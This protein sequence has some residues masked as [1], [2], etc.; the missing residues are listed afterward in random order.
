MS[1][2]ELL[3]KPSTFLFII[4]LIMSVIMVMLSYNLVIHPQASAQNV[5]TPTTAVSNGQTPIV[6]KTPDSNALP[7][8]SPENILGVSGDPGVIYPGISWVRIGYPTC[9]WGKLT[10]ELLRTTIQTYHKA[11]LRVLL[12]FCQKRNDEHLFDVAPLN[13]VAQ[14][15]A[16]AVQCGNEEMKLDPA[17]SF[18]FIPPERFARFYDLCE[19]TV[20]SIRP[21]LPVLLGSLDPHVGG[22]DYQ[23]LVQQKQYLDQMQ[24][25]MNT[26]VHAGGH[27]D[28][29]TQTLGLIDSWHNGWN[30]NGYPDAT[31]N[32]LQGLFSFWAEQ[33][34]V[35]LNSGQLGKHLWI[36]EGTGCFKG[37]GIDDK[38]PAQVAK[39]HIIALLTDVQTALKYSVPFFFFSAK[40]FVDQGYYWPIGLLDE[41]G[42]AKALRQD[43]PMGA[44]ALVLACTDGSITVVDQFQLLVN[45]YH[46]C[47]LPKDAIDSLTQ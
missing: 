43:L 34:G 24:V 38:N 31:V 2:P 45:L 40:D 36:V 1:L 42:K 7:V 15:M 6:E 22:I 28:W 10:G 12:I 27:W 26:T 29:H 35:D 41:Q 14:G 44:R 11:G 4:T 47:S 23:P 37:C 16:D 20:H 30:S 39:S 8:Q 32:S 21:E 3:K 18:L 33:F 25:A 19:H 46:R 13:D 5:V 17:V 9:G